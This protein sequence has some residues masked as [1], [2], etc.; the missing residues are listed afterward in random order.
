MRCLGSEGAGIRV[1]GGAP[2][3]QGLILANNSATAAGGGVHIV[4]G[5]EPL[6]ISDCV[7]VN[8]TAGHLG[9]GL[10]IQQ[11]RPWRANLGDPIWAPRALLSGI[12]SP[13]M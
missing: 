5:I 13:D 1:Q 12:H 7:F 11:A 10:S 3:L 6:T 4:P 2:R 9:G 8:N